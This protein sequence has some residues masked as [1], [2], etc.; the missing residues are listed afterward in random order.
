MSP[1]R[2]DRLAPMS[3]PC[4]N[5]QQLLEL[6]RFRSD[7]CKERIDSKSKDFLHH[8]TVTMTA[9]QFLDRAPAARQQLT[10]ALTASNPKK[11][12]DDLE[13]EP[14]KIPRIDGQANQG[15]QRPALYRHRRPQGMPPDSKDLAITCA[16]FI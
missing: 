11:R 16:L 9:A 8:A 13:P 12:T 10:R 6:T 1:T 2:F 4:R 5:Q 14:E 3:T 7:A 15:R